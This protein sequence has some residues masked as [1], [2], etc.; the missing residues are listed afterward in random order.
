[1]DNAS[2][3]VVVT[4]PVDWIA[5]NQHVY[6]AFTPNQRSFLEI[7]ADAG[8]LKRTCELVGIT[9]QAYYQ[10]MHG[11]RNF[12]MAFEAA[13]K[14][15]IQSLEDEVVRRGKDGIEEDVY[16]RDRVVGTRLRYSDTLLMFYLNG[17]APE[18]YRNRSSHELTGPGGGPVLTVS[19]LDELLKEKV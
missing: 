17:N 19:L 1:M 5:A 6:A 11:N 3:E 9:P 18:K 16:Y 13:K 15:A 8:S 14:M 7:Y 12:R 10:W 4:D 2:A